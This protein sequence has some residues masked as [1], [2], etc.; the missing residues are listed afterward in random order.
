CAAIAGQ[1][2]AQQVRQR[3]R[4]TRVATP[5]GRA[6][7]A[8]TTAPAAASRS[9]VA[10]GARP[11]AP[12][13]PAP[14][15]GGDAADASALAS[16]ACA[17]EMGAAAAGCGASA[18]R[19][20]GARTRAALRAREPTLGLPA[21]RRRVAEARPACLAEHG[22]ADPAHRPL[23][24]GAEAFGPELAAI[25]APASREHARLRLLHR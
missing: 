18:D 3:P 24:A 4:V 11:T 21:D 9:R 25:P 16:G 1:G 14:R 13:P 12:A 5:A 8:R 10:C 6:R 17:S 22:Q 20:S 15:T 19:R 23:W 7:T 2:P